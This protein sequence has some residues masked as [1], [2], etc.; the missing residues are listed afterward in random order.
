[1]KPVWAI[2][3]AL[4]PCPAAAHE[5]L[6]FEASA[7]SEDRRR[8]LSW[9]EGKAAARLSADLPLPAGFEISAEAT[10]ARGAVRHG[11]ADAA[12]DLRAGYRRDTGLLRLEGGAVLHS[13]AGG[14]G[15]QGFW[16][17]EAGTSVALGSLDLSLLAAFA[18]P[19]DAIGGSNFYRRA[20]L[21][22]GLPG[23]PVTL[24]AHFGKTT[25]SARQPGSARRLRPDGRYHDW[26]LGADYALGKWTLG[27]AYTDTD[28]RR[29]AHAGAAIVA[30]AHL[31][32]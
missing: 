32:F 25:G 31:A 5:A 9:S 13:L 27:L 18:P 22:A 20:R 21:R 17:L 12:I 15:N 30:G 1:M 8:G 24:S 16:E 23:T 2:T 14:R 19:Q 3:A 7:L 10:T 4:A 11:G 28:I 6:Q 26:S 29:G